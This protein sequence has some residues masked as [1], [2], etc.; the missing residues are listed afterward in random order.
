L[1]ESQK[2]IADKKKKKNGKN[3][4]IYFFPFRFIFCSTRTTPFIGFVSMTRSNW[5]KNPNLKPA[6]LSPIEGLI[7]G[8]CVAT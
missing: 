5:K 2:I 6:L 3:L 4:E 7:G 1:K 8:L